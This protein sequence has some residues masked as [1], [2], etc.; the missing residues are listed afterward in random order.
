MGGSNPLPGQLNP[1]TIEVLSQPAALTPAGLAD[2]VLS[3]YITQYFSVKLILANMMH[4]LEEQV[5]HGEQV[6]HCYLAHRN[7]F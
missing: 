2:Q 3:H 5:N 4:L 6:L 1:P 7:A